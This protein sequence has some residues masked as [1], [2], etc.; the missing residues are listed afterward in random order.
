MGTKRERR[1]C[2][3]GLMGL[4]STGNPEI[5]AKMGDIFALVGSCAF[6]GADGFL[7]LTFDGEESVHG[8]PDAA[9]RNVVA[10]RDVCA[11]E[12]KL[13][14]SDACSR[15]EGVVGGRFSEMVGAID[16]DIWG[17]IQRLLQ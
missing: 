8:S 5:L 11:R 16:R 4:L 1:V 15:C 7:L 6:D 13:V 9:R 17:Q 12:L 3:S 2:V 14:V 10:Q